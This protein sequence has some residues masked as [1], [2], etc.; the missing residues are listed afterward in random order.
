MHRAPLTTVLVL[1]LLLVAAPA[2]LADSTDYEQVVDLT[3]PVEAS[4]LTPDDFP[5]TFYADRGNDCGIHRA[6]DIMADHG[7]PVH[8][9]VGGEITRMDREYHASAGYW[10]VIEGDD[11]RQY[12]YIHLGQHSPEDA[13]AEGL[14][15]GDHVERGQLIGYAGS[16][17][18]ADPAWPHLHFEINDDN[19]A[20]PCATYINPWFSVTDA[21]ERGDVP[22]EEPD[23][24]PSPEPTEDPTEGPDPDPGE[25]VEVER[26]RA[27][28]R[29]GTSVE[30]SGQS[31]EAA[32]HVTVSSGWA[33]A[34][35]IVAGPLAYSR[36]GPVL[37]THPE[38]SDDRVL[39]EIARLGASSVTIVGSE[40]EVSST[41]ED[42]LAGVDGVETVER[43]AGEDVYATAAVV[44]EEVW[45]ANG[46]T[47][48][49]VAL[50]THSDPTRAWPD[51]LTAAYHGS[52]TGKPVLLVDEQHMPEVTRETLTGVERATVVGGT[53]SISEEIAEEI[54]TVAGEQRRLSGDDRF[55]TAIEVTDDVVDR[56][57]ANSGVLWSATGHDFADALA[58]APAVAETGGMFTLLDGY[59]E[60]GDGGID[61]WL[62]QMG[63]DVQV[64][65]GIGGEEAINGTALEDTAERLRQ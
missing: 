11:G 43:L 40:A 33:Y 31:F 8:A 24:G 51:S 7:T 39:E 54:G 59:A 5:D 35:T 45:S 21:W 36:G 22:G 57:L 2:A 37:S 3:F 1:A 53:L 34:E 38:Q 23:P 32:D 18:N 64:L 26:V 29:V 46:S 63:D 14:D 47:D 9:A 41:V 62:A 12:T 6:T 52:L 44:A 4:D 16:S 58:A 42:A 61:D 27:P 65:R 55:Q 30:L 48:A 17:G 15:V 20:G 49:L 60:G 50:G 19:V 28:D 56:G 13:Y 10:V 25:P